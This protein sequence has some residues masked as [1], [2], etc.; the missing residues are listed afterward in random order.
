LFPAKVQ[1]KSLFWLLTLPLEEI[2]EFLLRL[3]VSWLTLLD[4]IIYRHLARHRLLPISHFLIL[5]ALNATYYKLIAVALRAGPT[6]SD[7][8]AHQWQLSVYT[9]TWLN[10]SRANRFW[11]SQRWLLDSR[12]RAIVTCYL[13]AALVIDVVLLRSMALNRT[14]LAHFLA[15]I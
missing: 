2:C 5:L 7:F 1:V 12:S 3:C 4:D 14:W 6:R 11:A 15:N 13:V 10:I 8:I 9:C